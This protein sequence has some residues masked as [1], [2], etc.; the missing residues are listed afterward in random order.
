MKWK[1]YIN[2]P[3]GF[4][5]HGKTRF[6]SSFCNYGLK[7]YKLCGAE[8]LMAINTKV[9]KLK[10]CES[11]MEL[12]AYKRK[13]MV[14]MFLKTSSTHLAIMELHVHILHIFEIIGTH[15]ALW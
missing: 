5:S 7:Y 12:M 8:G 11:W 3:H 2:R 15:I 13:C 14:C 1:K 6:Y 10:L 9:M 4:A